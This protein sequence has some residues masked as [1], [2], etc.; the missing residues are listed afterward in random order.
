M[1]CYNMSMAKMRNLHVKNG[2]SFLT[3]L[4]FSHL[5]FMS[6]KSRIISNTSKIS[7]HLMQFFF[8]KKDRL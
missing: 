3:I 1:H 2:S 4:R 8:K 5:I 6:Y 7:A